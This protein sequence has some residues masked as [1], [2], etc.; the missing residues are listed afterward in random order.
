[1]KIENKKVTQSDS[2]ESPNF[3]EFVTTLGK[4]KPGQSFFMTE[5]RPHYRIAISVAQNLLKARFAIRK[6]GDGFRV[7]RVT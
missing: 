2:R 4:L 6:E 1:M 5:V 7:G 3:Q